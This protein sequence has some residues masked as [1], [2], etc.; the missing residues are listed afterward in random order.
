MFDGKGDNVSAKMCAGA[1]P[2]SFLTATLMLNC[3]TVKSL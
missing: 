2:E 1:Y 3:G